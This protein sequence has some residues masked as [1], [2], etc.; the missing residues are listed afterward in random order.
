MAQRVL[1]IDDSPQLQR[2]VSAWL[3]PDALDIHFADSAA[4]GLVESATLR[5][6]LI[7]LDV[8]MPGMNGF[9]LC[10]Q[11]KS[12][13]SMAA[14]PIVFLTG[15]AA[16]EERVR[17]LNLG[18]VDYIVKPFHP[19]EFQARVRAALRTKQLLDLLQ[20]RAQI[21]G[22]T[23]LHNRAYFDER[24]EAELA[25]HHRRQTPISCVMLDVDHFKQV[26]DRWGHLTGDDV[27]RVIAGLLLD[28]TRTEDVVARY[29]GEEF[30]ILT[31]GVDVAG[32]LTLAERLR[33]TVEKTPVHRLNGSVRITCSLGV[34]GH[35]GVGAASLVDCADAA[36]YAAKAGGRNRVT[37]FESSMLPVV[38]HSAA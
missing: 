35:A 10:K 5:P 11:I 32:A 30:I 34:A 13:P 28:G 36:L 12:D 4:Q 37:L 22:L 25:V 23:S 20:E 7:L 19:A 1:I 26:N 24:L 38:L 16:P 3:K 21:D 27:L 17:G 15:A 8:D 2:L 9:D 29:G 33:A 6:D 18:A 14:I 31:P